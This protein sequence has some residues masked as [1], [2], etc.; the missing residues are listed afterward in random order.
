MVRFYI[1]LPGGTE[2]KSVKLGDL[3]AAAKAIFSGFQMDFS[4]ETFWWSA[5]SIGQRLA[6]NFSKDNR[7]FLAGDACHT[8][9]PKA[10]QGMNLSLAD[11]YNLGWKLATVLR[12]L[13]S[14]ELLETYISE[15]QPTA[16]D[17]IA[18]DREITSM[19][20]SESAEDHATASKA[21]SDY[22]VKS[23]KYAAGLTTTYSDS[24]I[25]NAK[26]SVPALAK[27]VTI[28]SR[29]PSAQ[30]VRLS[31]ARA[32]QLSKALNSS[33]KWRIMVLAGD[34]TDDER[35]SRLDALSQFLSS[36][37]SPIIGLTPAGARPDVFTPITGKHKIRGM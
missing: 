4:E 19:L 36:K 22:F 34:I 29:F 2:P 28:G 27:N 30:A 25:I 21:Y 17:L 1:Q 33:G 16:A 9:S 20:K 12:G 11:G 31:D 15:R 7:V 24:M 37:Q 8:H 23:A 14:P 32:I 3:Q 6:D 26:G 5:Y 35:K 13:A 18:F 10:G